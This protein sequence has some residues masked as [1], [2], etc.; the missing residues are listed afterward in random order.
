[1]GRWEGQG[2]G[3]WGRVEFRYVRVGRGMVSIRPFRWATPSTLA[4]AGFHKSSKQDTVVR[5]A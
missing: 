4:A 2:W 3:R 1:M 5:R